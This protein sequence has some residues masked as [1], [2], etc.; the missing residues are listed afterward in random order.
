MPLLD[1][2]Q[3]YLERSLRRCIQVLIH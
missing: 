3:I 1:L 2:Q